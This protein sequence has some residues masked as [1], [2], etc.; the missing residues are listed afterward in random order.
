MEER[1]TGVISTGGDELTKDTEC[2]AG[3]LKRKHEPNG[4]HELDGCQEMEECQDRTTA[5]SFHA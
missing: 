3:L 5:F 2:T 4:S 1:R